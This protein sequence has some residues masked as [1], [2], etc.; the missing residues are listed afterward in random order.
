MNNNKNSVKLSTYR[1]SYI[2]AGIFFVM[3]FAMC[4]T[5]YYFSGSLFFP[6]ILIVSCVI[7]IIG[8]AV[9]CN[10]CSIAN[11]IKNPD[12][13]NPPRDMF[14]Y[15]KRMGFIVIMTFLMSMG[16]S[17]IGTFANAIVGGMLYN[18]IESLFLRGFIIKLPMFVL[19]LS[20]V[21]RMYIRYGFMDC[22]RKIFNLNFK[23]LT[24]IISLIIML[25]NAVYDS[26]FFTSTLDTFI[27]NVQT[28]FSPNIDRLIVESDGF[29]RLNEDFNII[30]VIVTLL[31]T[32]TIQTAVAW[33]AYNR[34]KQIFI[35]EHIRKL[36]EYEMNENIWPT[37]K[38]TVG[39]GKEHDAIYKLYYQGHKKYH[40]RFS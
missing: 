34:G 18:N 35:K 6:L 13:F 14:Y 23:M 32:F 28:V 2:I 26:M 12:G 39:E 21:Y 31:L 22:E 38:I 37:Q 8:A 15:I 11:K 7:A 30:L 10:R 3:V 33:F 16:V 25:P 24:M 17:F 1:N 4:L 9:V 27:V 40:Q 19:Y 5:A 20:F 29:S 36:D